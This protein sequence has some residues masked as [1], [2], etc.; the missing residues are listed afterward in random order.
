MSL[1]E[2]HV[3]FVGALRSAG[4]TVS[5]AEGLDATAAIGQ[6]DLIDR[7]QLRAAYAATL[8]KRQIHRSTFDSIFDLYYPPVT[9]V[10][11]VD[12][13]PG[14]QRQQPRQ[15]PPPWEIDN[16]ERLA[17]RDGLREYLLSGD[18]QQAQ[19][20]AREAM[21][22]FGAVP[23]TGTGGSGR[24]S[25]SPMTVLDRISPRTLLANVLEQFLNGQDDGGLA[26]QT[27]RTTIEARLRRFEQLVEAD[28]RR[29]L[30]E[31]SSAE[32]V[33][34]TGVRPS[35]DNV[36]FL[37][38]SRAELAAL[39]REIQPLARRLAARFAIDQR[40]GHRGQLDFRHT[41]RASLS[42]GGV[43]MQIVHR[44]KR[45]VKTDLV[46][47]CDI[48]ESVTSFA[49][50]TLLLVYALREQFSRVRTFA[51]VDELDE[52]TRFFA[53]G[54]DVVD[55]VTRLVSEAN[56]TGLFGRTDYGRAFDLFERRYPEAIGRRTSL[57]ILGDAR[58]NYGDV[59]IPALERMVGRAK[60]S[61]WLN[62]E[63]QRLWDSGDSEASKVAKVIDMVECR[64]LAQLSAF[65]KDLA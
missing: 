56:V 60:H 12:V 9:G 51:F 35:L 61:Y 25:W 20:L 63:R 30:A 45:P 53:P 59:G 14:E 54:A 31:Q 42:T 44:P 19:Q 39:R 33:A 6:I 26:E 57:L 52:V 13:K 46:I 4:L 10:E 34:R 16:P 47:L 11:G 27:A 64:N 1:F 8:M 15:A 55:S 28:A 37:G 22:G 32:Q 21:A 5:I 58:S 62:P 50:F 17:I 49:H 38:A 23:G 41:I 29:R 2:H 36:S 18:D 48:S 24:P 3:A 7:E 65:V 40:R 43:P